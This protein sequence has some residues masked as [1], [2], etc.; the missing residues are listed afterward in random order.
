MTAHSIIRWGL[1]FTLVLGIHA[2]GAAAL[3]VQWTD[4]LDDI[5]NAPAMMV[6]L[7]P[8][9]AAPE[10]TPSDV[11]IGRRQPDAAAQV[12]P[13][14]QIEKPA[15]APETAHPAML[16][17]PRPTEVSREPRARHKHA[18]LSAVPSRADN[19]ATQARAPAPGAVS[20]NPNALPNWR[21]ALVARLERYK[22]YPAAA[23]ASGASGVVQ[24]AFSVDRSG[25][26]HH[27]RIAQSSGSHLLDEA[28]LALIERAQ[29]LPPPPSEL[30]GAE[31]AVM[32]PIRY[33]MR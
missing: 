29:P 15:V 9:P 13:E 31:I 26:V 7:A 4:R 18:S 3:L 6:E 2:A 14:K 27:A 28:T 22:R 20:Q 8:L 32:V 21:S 11:P 30:R 25:R 33:S 12:R 23:Q 16:P 5:A 24:L 1:C 19:N 17:P 10:T